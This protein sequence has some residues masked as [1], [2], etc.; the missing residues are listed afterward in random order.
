MKHTI[1]PL[2]VAFTATAT[3]L[4][5]ALSV[6]LPGN[7]TSDGWDQLT[8]S[9]LSGYGGYPGLTPWTTPIAA[10]TSGSDQNAVFNKIS[11]GG[12]LANNSFYDG[13]NSG[14][15][16]LQSDNPIANLATVIFQVDMGMSTFASAPQLLINGTDL[17]DPVASSITQGA[18]SSGQ[19]GQPP[20]FTKNHA[21]QW[22]LTGYGA[23]I[24]D[25]QVQWTT[26]IH[27]TIYEMHLDS[28]DSFATVIPEPSTAFLGALAGSLL[29]L[30]RRS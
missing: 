8:N 26:S 28:G 4:T 3:S 27:T 19:P 22:D 21:F 10:N 24:D 13:G 7:S 5:A 9:R 11:G 6:T 12:Y 15:L 25:Y 16:A 1:A 2:F 20:S 18:Y 29:L 23:T 14:T 30:R 17:L